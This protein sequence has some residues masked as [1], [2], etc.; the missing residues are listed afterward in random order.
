MVWQKQEVRDHRSG[1]T[2]IIKN[3]PSSFQ[4]ECVNLVHDNKE[5]NLEQRA[6]SEYWTTFDA[7]ATIRQIFQLEDYIFAYCYDDPVTPGDDIDGRV[8]WVY[9]DGTSV[10]WTEVETEGSETTYKIRLRDSKNKGIDIE[11][12]EGDSFLSDYVKT[13]ETTA[14]QDVPEILQVSG[15]FE[16]ISIK[17]LNSRLNAAGYYVRGDTA[18]EYTYEDMKDEIEAYGPAAGWTISYSPLTVAGDFVHF[19][20]SLE[21]DGESTDKIEGVGVTWG[22]WLETFKP[23]FTKEGHIGISQWSG[24]MF[25]ALEPFNKE[26]TPNDDDPYAENPDAFPPDNDREPLRKLY[27]QN[28][29]NVISPVIQNA[30]ESKMYLDY[31]YSETTSTGTSDDS[32]RYG[33]QIVRCRQSLTTSSVTVAEIA[34]YYERG[35]APGPS[36]NINGLR[37][38]ITG[39][40]QIRGNVEDGAIPWG[41]YWINLNFSGG[42]VQSVMNDIVSLL[43]Q[44]ATSNDYGTPFSFQVVLESGRTTDNCAAADTSDTSGVTIPPTLLRSL[45]PESGAGVYSYAYGAYMRN[46]F[47]AQDEGAPQTYID[48]GPVAFLSYP[49][50]SEI[51]NRQITFYQTG[52]GAGAFNTDKYPTIWIGRNKNYEYSESIHIPDTD[53]CVVAR[54]LANGSVAYINRFVTEFEEISSN[55]PPDSILYGDQ[56]WDTNVGE[57]FEF[58]DRF[59]DD[60]LELNETAYYNGGVASHDSLPQQGSYYFTVVNQTGYHA[61]VIGNVARVYESAPGVPF[62]APGLFFEDFDDVITGISHFSNKPIIFTPNTTWRWEGTNGATG[63]GRTFIRVV[64]DEFGCIANQSIVRTNRGLFYWSKTGVIFTDGLKAIRVT[65][66]LI[67]RYADWL[68]YIQSSG[69]EIGPRNLR[70]TYDEINRRVLWSSDDTNGDPIVIVLD[71]FEG[72]SETMPVFMEGGNTNTDWDGAQYN[73]TQMYKTSA[74]F[75]SEDNNSVFRGQD[76]RVLKVNKDISYDQYWDGTD[77][78]NIPIRPYLKSVAFD[79]G[80]RSNVKWTSQI[81]WGFEDLGQKGVSLQ[82]LG[83]ND[84]SSEPHELFPMVNYQHMEWAADYENTPPIG[85]EQFF[86]HSDVSWRTT[87]LV[88]YK[89]KFPRG[90]IRNTFK[91]YGFTHMPIQ[92]GTLDEGS[93]NVDTITVTLKSGTGAPLKEITVDVS[94]TLD[95][96]LIDL[97][98]DN[99]GSFYVKWDNQDVL[100]KIHSFVLSGSTY[101]LQVYQGDESDVDYAYTEIDSLTIAR[102]FSDQIIKMSDYTA[103]FQNLGDATIGPVRTSAEGGFNGNGT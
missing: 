55:T 37:V 26:F 75:F 60:D 85:L 74:L 80:D 28:H 84:I 39:P 8:Y 10:A 4:E 94:D 41:Q 96:A 25:L 99:S 13:T 87:H 38:F 58:E 102:V 88:Q 49:S 44:K 14:G 43:N 48:D 91:A 15:T 3:S 24:N 31:D 63:D 86:K 76:L 17:V 18:M 20:G 53:K 11:I 78:F 77:T 6:G 92:L 29:D 33:K 52:A 56:D 54:T 2:D 72:I 89:R 47:Q 71:V 79:Y 93:G 57:T 62:S 22:R 73:K 69:D 51:D 90:K 23:C 34:I 65:E 40:Q 95:N 27:L 70:G 67:E 100:L 1:I 7:P 82:P 97:G 101:T 66:H 61:N 98:M 59:N 35:I 50:L 68:T 42:T 83:W 30:Q 45:P 21:V 81:L 5:G 32:Y 16:Y 64:S 12:P 36:N 19:S 9:E 103:T 46:S